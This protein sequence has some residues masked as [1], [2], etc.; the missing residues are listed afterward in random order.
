MKN[1]PER[2][3]FF[4]TLFT[5]Y[6][7]FRK[8]NSSYTI[9]RA[10]QI[11]HIDSVSEIFPKR[12]VLI[13]RWNGSMEIHDGSYE[14]RSQDLPFPERLRTRQT[15][16]LSKTEYDWLNE[17]IALVNA[18]LDIRAKWE[19]HD[20]G[21]SYIGE[22]SQGLMDAQNRIDRMRLLHHTLDIIPLWN[23][24]ERQKEEDP[25]NSI[26][27]EMKARISLLEWLV[28]LQSGA[29]EWYQVATQKFMERFERIMLGRSHR[30]SE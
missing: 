25:T 19:T 21:T 3:F 29:L 6:L 23:S 14:D 10:E 16:T 8:F 5:F 17:Y 30:R 28:R 2:E 12:V 20:D 11:V 18:I 27:E 15:L 4:L 26:I 9:M 24:N 13:E 1:T 7:Y 22:F